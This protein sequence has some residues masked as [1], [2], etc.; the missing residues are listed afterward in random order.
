M[1]KRIELLHDITSARALRYLSIN[2]N[3]DIK[4]V[5]TI[6]LKE[7]SMQDLKL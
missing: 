7:I 4:S 5:L 2:K 6:V 1:F 3:I